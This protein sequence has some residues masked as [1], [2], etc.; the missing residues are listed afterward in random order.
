VPKNF[1]SKKPIC[2]YCEKKIVSKKPY[3]PFFL[4]L[5]I[6]AFICVLSDQLRPST[7]IWIL[8][9]LGSTAIGL[10]I[11]YALSKLFGYNVVEEDKD[12]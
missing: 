1:F 11:L 10:A 5:I 2:K 3:I 8:I 9:I 4:S 12:K 7:I 6:I